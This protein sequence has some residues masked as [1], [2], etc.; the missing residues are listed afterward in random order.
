MGFYLLRGHKI[1]N[2]Q[3]D[4]SPNPYYEKGE[5]IMVEDNYSEESDANLTHIER[6]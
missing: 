1:I 5:N 4:R 6:D 3:K 2:E